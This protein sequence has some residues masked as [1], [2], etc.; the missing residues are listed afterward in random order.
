MPAIRE[1]GA[2]QPC[3]IPDRKPAGF[4]AV[5]LPSPG[6]QALRASTNP[7]T[8]STR[9]K[10]VKRLVFILWYVPWQ[11]S[12]SKLPGLPPFQFSP[13]YGNWGALQFSKKT[14]G[15]FHEISYTG[16][17]MNHRDAVRQLFEDSGFQARLSALGFF[18]MDLASGRAIPSFLWQSLGYGSEPMIGQTIMDLVH[19]DDAGHLAVEM[20]E[21]LSGKM[22][23][24]SRTFR[25]SRSDGSWAWLEVSYTILYRSADGRAEVILGHDQDV[26]SIKRAEQESRER[27]DELE[28]IRQVARD[29]GRSLDLQE[30]VTAILEHT[31]RAIP[32]DKATVQLLEDC[33]LQVMGSYGF[34]DPSATIKLRFKYPVKG[35]PSTLALKSKKPVVCNDVLSGFPGFYQVPSEKPILSWLGIPL[36]ANNE[37]IGLMALDSTLKDFYTPRHQRIAE[38]VGSHMALAMEKAFLYRNMQ[39]MA[40]TDSL[41]GIGNRYSLRIQGSLVFEHAKANHKIL[42]FLMADLDHFKELNDSL[43]HDAG[44]VVLSE[45]AALMS[46]RL[47]SQDLFIRYGGEEFLAILSDTESSRGWEIAERIRCALQNH[48]FAGIARQVTVSIGLHSEV[49]GPEATLMDFITAADK[50]LY[51]AKQ[52]GRNRVRSSCND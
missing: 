11:H 38:M 36:I 33:W 43:G 48:E 20:E 26:D 12:K 35:S 40:K 45:A 34:I 46:S 13:E 47:R 5:A 30:T 28:T 18:V 51:K 3:Q 8:T 22:D 17:S 1:M 16:S 7:R 29:L 14:L 15:I 31:R 41:T 42:T 23:T 21:L 9:I 37:V 19:P 2:I 27:L 50:A 4:S 6:R 32:Y 25:L 52:Q 10:V 24:L 49:P 39:E 44:D